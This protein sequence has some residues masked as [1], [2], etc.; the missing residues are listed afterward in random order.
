MT[1]HAAGNGTAERHNIYLNKSAVVTA[2]MPTPGE[3]A[4]GYPPGSPV[5]V[6]TADFDSGEKERVFPG[7]WIAVAFGD[8]EGVPATEEVTAAAEYVFAVIA[9]E[10]GNAGARLAALAA[11]A[12]ASPG[13][14]T[15]LAAEYRGER[16]AERACAAAAGADG[17]GH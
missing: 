7:N 10:L 12:G 17:S 11:A 5:L 1:Q 2:R 16:D 6:V 9:E 15:R 14:V 3:C 4:L 8:P 13:A